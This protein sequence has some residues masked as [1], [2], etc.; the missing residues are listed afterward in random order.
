M[1]QKKESNFE[2]QRAINIVPSS[3]QDYTDLASIF[4]DRGMATYSI[5]VLKEGI[6]RLTR[7]DYLFLVLSDFYEKTGAIKSASD[8]LREYLAKKKDNGT[9]NLLVRKKLAELER[10]L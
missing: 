3:I 8:V 5:E 2:F 10:D 9:F 6:S 4:L 7:N 1:G